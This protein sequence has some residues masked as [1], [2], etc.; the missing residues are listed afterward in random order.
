MSTAA[1][2]RDIYATFD[3]I[4]KFALSRGGDAR[5]LTPTQFV[6]FYNNP[7][8]FVSMHGVPALLV[9]ARRLTGRIRERMPVPQTVFL[10]EQY[11]LSGD[12]L[13]HVHKMLMSGVQ[14]VIAVGVYS[15][16]IC[17]KKRRMQVIEHGRELKFTGILSGLKLNTGDLIW[18]GRR[19]VQPT[20]TL[21]DPRSFLK[22]HRVRKYTSKIFQ[23]RRFED[24]RFCE[25][26]LDIFEMLAESENEIADS[27]MW[28]S[29]AVRLKQKDQIQDATRRRLNVSGWYEDDSLQFLSC[30]ASGI[31]LFEKWPT[32]NAM[33]RI[34]AWRDLNLILACGEGMPRVAGRR[35]LRR[36][37]MR[38]KLPVYILSDND[39]WG[40]FLFSLLKRGSFAP[41]LH[42][43][44]LAIDDVRYVGA[45][46]GEI[47]ERD[48]RDHY[49]IKW[50]E[51]WDLRLSAMRKYDCFR[52]KAWATEFD[53]FKQQRGK[54]DIEGLIYRRDIRRTQL[55]A[56][57]LFM[58]E[59]LKPKLQRQ[60]WLT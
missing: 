19:E 48:D 8:Y 58:K 13:A 54:F 32:F 42:I 41:H 39:T 24:Q 27:R 6:H 37:A 14:E 29:G 50:E 11:G 2:P 15:L 59:Y 40:Y 17:T 31:L 53:R 21:F 16:C 1:R 4:R 30:S 10:G 23:L 55:A 5:T 45:R 60:E 52:S 34:K 9:Y 46:A 25:H 3:R 7:R 18:P 43:P 28:L 12:A 57:R 36:L 47:D 56:Y 49:L 26:E 20:Q 44:Q 51:R 35:I 22:S 33:H 38:F